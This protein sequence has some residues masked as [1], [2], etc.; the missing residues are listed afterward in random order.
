MAKNIAGSMSEQ[1]K[2]NNRFAGLSPAEALEKV[3]REEMEIQRQNEERLGGTLGQPGVG[4]DGPTDE[5][6]RMVTPKKVIER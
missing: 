4:H 1:I 3:H 2:H 5:V 6:R